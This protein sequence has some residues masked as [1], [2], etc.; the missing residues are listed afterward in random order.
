MIAAFEALYTAVPTVSPH[1]SLFKVQY[2]L[3]SFWFPH[4]AEV[5]SNIDNRTSKPRPSI[6]SN[7]NILTGHIF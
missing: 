4:E 6:M 3:T 7:S 5:A 2:I 1:I